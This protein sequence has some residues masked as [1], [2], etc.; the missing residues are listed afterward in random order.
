MGQSMVA[1]RPASRSCG[2]GLPEGE[3]T[4]TW[5]GRGS[6]LGG[7]D[8]AQRARGRGG[9]RHRSRIW[10]RG[11]SGRQVAGEG[12][13]AAER[14]IYDDDAV[15]EARWGRRRARGQASRQ[16]LLERNGRKVSGVYGSEGPLGR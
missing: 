6:G 5:G 13:G 9:C 10:S 2:G 4:R 3:G 16:L 7:G 11:R 8:G 1:E 12:T 15:E 14:V